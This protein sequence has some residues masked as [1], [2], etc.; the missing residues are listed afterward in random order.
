MASFTRVQNPSIAAARPASPRALG[1]LSATAFVLDVAVMVGVG[2]LA[3]VARMSLGMFGELSLSTILRLEPLL[4]AVWLLVL[5]TFGAYRR[6][7]FGAGIEEY[8]I[9]ANGTMVAGA[10]LGTAS[11]LLNS[12][13]S[14]SFFVLTFLFGSGLLLAERGLLRRAVHRAR[15]RGVLRHDVLIAGTAANVDNIAGV[16]ARESWLGYHVMGALVPDAEAGDETSR[17]VPVLGT[18][19]QALPVLAASDADIIF[20][21]GGALYSPEQTRRLVYDLEDQNVEVVV[22]PSVT[23]VARERVQIRP[24]AGLPLVHIGAP[25]SAQ[26]TRWAKRVF[27]VVGAAAPARFTPAFIFA[28]CPSGCT[29]A[30]PSTSAR[31]ASGGTGMS[32]TA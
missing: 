17:G 23:D 9:M 13:L 22:A 19:D 20:V 5:V 14:R 25:R 28:A 21:A 3:A 1:S 12:E 32:S 29:T 27:D 18:P 8:K 6:A 7:L 11:Y 26:A 10:L 16:L 24:V 4:I 31:S 2:A 15:R 30:A